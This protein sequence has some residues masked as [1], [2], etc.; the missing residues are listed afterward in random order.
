MSAVPS[1]SVG[2]GV[3]ILG[4]APQLRRA[5]ALAERFA[6]SSLSV[7][8]QGATG[9][10]KEL[11]ARCIHDWSRRPGRFVPVNC[12]ALPSTM[13]ESLLFGHRR[14]AFTDAHESAPGFIDAADKGTLYLDELGSFPLEGQVKLL[15]VLES[16]EVYRLGETGPRPVDL[17]VVASVQTS[18][19]SLVASGVLRLDLCERVAGV[20]ITLP[21]LRE[22][23][24]DVF[25][26]A[27]HFARSRGKALG[28]GVSAVL[29]DY[30]WPGNVR[31]LRAV[32]E[33]AGA[34]ADGGAI[35][36]GMIA[37]AIELGAPD[38]R[39]AA[40]FP[41]S[42]RSAVELE[43]RDRLVAACEANGWHAGRTAAS[44]GLARVTIYRRL[45]RMGVSLRARKRLHTVS[46]IARH[47]GRESESTRAP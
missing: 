3:E 31:E 7:L 25:V 18:P 23:G 16:Q 37:E 43:E 4:E 35:E 44:L 38:V 17:R 42:S 46:R 9:T 5:L 11:L 6:R 45:R 21:T 27:D 41:L 33:R 24:N 20:V 40:S 47:N 32:L 12:G 10:G 2:L 36:S 29:R 34:L 15:R 22:R 39:G 19:A 8:L 14:G 28:L 1:S 26:L 30:G 13:I